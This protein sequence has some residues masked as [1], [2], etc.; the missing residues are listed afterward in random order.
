VAAGLDGPVWYITG[1]PG[2]TGTTVRISGGSGPQVF[3]Q[4]GKR[5]AVDMGLSPCSPAGQASVGGSA[6]WFVNTSTGLPLLFSFGGSLQGS[7]DTFSS[8]PSV[9]ANTSN[10]QL[11]VSHV[12]VDTAGRVWAVGDPGSCDCAG[13]L[14]ERPFA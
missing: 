1:T 13:E 8:V 12:A 5:I 11:M 10:G 14:L 7:Y 2:T 9:E 6:M 4:G 3:N